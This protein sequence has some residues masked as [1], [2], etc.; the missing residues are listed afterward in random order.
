[1]VTIVPFAPE[2]AE[3]VASLILAIQQREFGIP[4]GWEDQP[5]LHDIPAFYRRGAG[6]FWV[7]VAQGAVVGTIALDDRG[8]GFGVLRKMFV[9]PGHRGAAHG[10]AAGLLAALL[11]RARERGLATILLGTTSRF[12]AAHRF[13]EKNGFGEI[14]AE[15]LPAAFPRLAVDTKF[16]RLDLSRA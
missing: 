10:V 2:H 9:A 3:G 16:F 12:L 8:E 7:A 6:D 1:M 11:A 15:A 5:D 14:P 13:Y 4:I